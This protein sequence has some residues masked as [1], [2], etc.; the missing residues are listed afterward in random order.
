MDGVVVDNMSF[1]ERA[2][3]RFF[4]AR[5]V[6]MDGD[7]FFRKT[8]GMPT[9]EVLAYF[10]KRELAAGE[11]AACHREKE[12]LYRDLYRPHLAPLPG[13]SAFLDRCR[14]AGLRIGLGTGSLPDNIDFV[15]DGLALRGRFEAIVGA[16]EVENGKPHPET[17]L[18]LAG[19]LGVPPS[20]CVVFEDSLLGEKA[21]RA[22]GMAVVAVTTSHAASDFASPDLVVA[23]FSGLEPAA[24]LKILK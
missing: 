22:A 6:A 17:F 13:L 3:R 8:S 24:L 12:E 19:R 20:R 5:G 1:H 7:E 14:A 10:F 9:R 16:H 18:T 4:E 21:A 2:W 11:A 15:L 23:D